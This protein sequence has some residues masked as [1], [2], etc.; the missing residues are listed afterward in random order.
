MKRQLTTVTPDLNIFCQDT[1]TEPFFLDPLNLSWK[2]YIPSG[3]W[4]TLSQQHTI[5][6]HKTRILNNTAVK[7]SNLRR[8]TSY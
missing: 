5:T 1:Q 6:S 3:H 8:S 4:D 2:Y 7:T